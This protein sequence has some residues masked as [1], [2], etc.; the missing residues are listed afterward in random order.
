ME[1][2]QQ[3]KSSLTPADDPEQQYRQ[4]RSTR[5]NKIRTKRSSSSVSN[6]NQEE[7]DEQNVSKRLLRK[8]TS[9]CYHRP[10]VTKPKITNEKSEQEQPTTDENQDPGIWV[11]F[12]FFKTSRFLKFHFKLIPI[13]CYILQMDN[14]FEAQD[15]LVNANPTGLY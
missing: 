12:F 15:W 10:Q 5:L 8:R 9:L 3:V 6:Y 11:E 1:L 14:I 13:L 7:N 4:S 2:A